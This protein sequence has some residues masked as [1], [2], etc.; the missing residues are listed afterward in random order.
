LGNASKNDIHVENKASDEK[1]YSG[2]GSTGRSARIYAMAQA[3]KDL[4]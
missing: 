3:Y 4:L 2:I 1:N